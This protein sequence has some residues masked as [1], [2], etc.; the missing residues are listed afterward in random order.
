MISSCSGES[1][2][3]LGGR[4]KKKLEKRDET[5]ILIFIGSEKYG[6]VIRKSKFRESI[7]AYDTFS[8][9][10]R[11]STQKGSGLSVCLILKMQ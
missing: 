7:R 9:S 6:C 4:N 11:D 1:Y 3:H 10:A 5:V 2:S 8:V